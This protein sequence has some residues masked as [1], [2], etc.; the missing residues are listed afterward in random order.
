VVAAE[1]FL[2]RELGNDEDA[3]Q[4]EVRQDRDPRGGEVETTIGAR[5]VPLPGTA[6]RDDPFSRP[7]GR[8]KPG[9]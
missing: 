1:G 4:H 2:R 3:E 8:Q 5:V 6:V 7:L 9:L